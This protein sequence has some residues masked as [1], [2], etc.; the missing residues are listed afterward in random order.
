MLVCRLWNYCLTLCEFCF[1]FCNR[2]RKLRVDRWVWHAVAMAA[3]SLP[4]L[5]LIFCFCCSFCHSNTSVVE[6]PSVLLCNIFGLFCH[7]DDCRLMFLDCDL[8]WCKLFNV[9]QLILFGTGQVCICISQVGW[10][11]FC[12][13]ST[14]YWQD[15]WFWP[16]CKSENC[17]WPY[18]L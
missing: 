13:F 15:L 18:W 8:I 9:L 7:M 10:I 1:W 4:L 14:Q 11:V 3:D 6:D 5:L 16:K 17:C 2:R 12:L